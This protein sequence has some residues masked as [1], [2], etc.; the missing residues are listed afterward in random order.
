MKL[1]RFLEAL[2]AAAQAVNNPNSRWHPLW[3]G[4]IRLCQRIWYAFKAV[5]WRKVLWPCLCLVTLVW[6]AGGLFVWGVT[7]GIEVA[8]VQC[9]GMIP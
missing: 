6:I 7:L 5:N 4:V 9:L 2:L 1:R 8:K 3:I